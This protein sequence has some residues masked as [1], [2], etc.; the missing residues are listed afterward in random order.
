MFNY[1]LIP[2]G[3][4][5]TSL[6]SPQWLISVHLL[7]WFGNKLPNHIDIPLNKD[8]KP[9][10]TWCILINVTKLIVTEMFGNQI[11]ILE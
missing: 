4:V 10:Q 3:K 9:S 7:E 1:L 5:W 8:T 6:Y 2:L 11:R